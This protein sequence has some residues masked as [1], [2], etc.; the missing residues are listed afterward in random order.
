MKLKINK[1]N[2]KEVLEYYMLGYSDK[3][4]ADKF[5]LSGSNIFR[6]RARKGLTANHKC[7]IQKNLNEKELS[8]VKSNYKSKRMHYDIKPCNMDRKSRY[9][10]SQKVKERRVKH[11]NLPEVKARRKDYLERPEIKISR[12]KYSEEYRNDTENK[13][14]MREYT[15]EYGQRQNVKA[16]KKEYRDRQE[17]K[18]KRKNYNKKL[19][20]KLVAEALEREDKRA[21]SQWPPIIGYDADP[22]V[23]AVA[24]KNIINAGLKDRI[25]INQRQLARLQPP[26]AKGIMVT[27][28]PYGERLSEKAAVK[29]LYRCLGR[30]FR[31]AFPDWQL[32]F[33]TANPDLADMLGF[34][35]AALPAP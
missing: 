23:V 19:W 25:I 27:N 1:S 34:L 32:G 4:I 29:Y 10:K 6:W 33:S 31:N 7:N 17:S 24:R 30:T 11:N 35:A 12:A 9:D 26:A 8:Y 13:E 22:H 21:E 28:P 14:K 16:R 20:E 5:N 2:E 15:K 3:R 18:E